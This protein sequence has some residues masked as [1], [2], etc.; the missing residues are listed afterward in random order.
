[1]KYPVNLYKTGENTILSQLAKVKFHCPRRVP[2]PHDS[3]NPGGGQGVDSM[4]INRHLRPSI[5]K[6]SAVV[7][8]RNPLS[9]IIGANVN[10]PETSPLIFPN[11]CF[12]PLSLPLFCYALS[13]NLNDI[14]ILLSTFFFL[15][16]DPN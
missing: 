11:G 13:S 4:N 14:F 9:L 3:T 15:H 1:M 12:T 7:C 10:L 6:I 2:T 5:A 8:I 16:I